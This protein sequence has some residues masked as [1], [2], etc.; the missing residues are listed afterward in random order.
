[1]GRESI[2]SRYKAKNPHSPISTS[3]ASR[4]YLESALDSYIKWI[5]QK[6]TDVKYRDEIESI[7]NNQNMLNDESEEN[8]E[9]KGSPIQEK[10]PT[11]THRMMQNKLKLETILESIKSF[12]VDD[13]VHLQTHAK[14]DKLLKR[15]KSKRT[16]PVDKERMMELAKPKRTLLK[17]SIVRFRHLM[18]ERKRKRLECR[19]SRN[20]SP[21]EQMENEFR[22]KE[23][24]SI[25]KFHQ[26]TKPIE[27]AAINQLLNKIISSSHLTDDNFMKLDDIIRFSILNA[28]QI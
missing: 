9:E 22:Q 7:L 27:R 8:E 20:L 3:K 4:K 15:M 23:S 16:G 19:L 14:F 25:A 18:S 13:D 12:N 26:K 5:E 24:Q 28:L 21:P 11:H 1:M 6:R 17:F 10:M 2:P